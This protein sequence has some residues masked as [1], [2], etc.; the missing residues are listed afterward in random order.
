MIT[1]GGTLVI[2]NMRKRKTKKK[3]SENDTERGA[4]HSPILGR[5]NDNRLR[6]SD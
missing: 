5:I 1:S 6:I 2:S 4:I 3:V